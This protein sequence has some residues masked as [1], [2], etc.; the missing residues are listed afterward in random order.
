MGITAWTLKKSLSF[1]Q[2]PF[3]MYFES[4]DS[5]W[6]GEIDEHIHTGDSALLQRLTWLSGCENYSLETFLNLWL[7]WYVVA[8]LQED[9]GIYQSKVRELISDNQYRLI[10]NVNDLRRKNE[11]R[12]NRWVARRY[13]RSQWEW[14]PSLLARLKQPLRRGLV[15]NRIDLEVLI[16]HL[17]LLLFL[18][19]PKSR[20][21]AFSSQMLLLPMFSWI[22]FLYLW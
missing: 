2:S 12:A 5:E 4:K 16:A 17:H 7:W 6:K 14:L 21:L 13:T 20:W 9:Q 11:K 1:L 15:W 22:W 8:V 18:F 19:F 10:V 3:R